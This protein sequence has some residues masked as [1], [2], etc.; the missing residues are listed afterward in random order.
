MQQIINSLSNAEPSAE[1][2]KLHMQALYISISTLSGIKK[3]GEGIF[4]LFSC[5]HSH[6][7]TLQ[8]S[9]EKY[10]KLKWTRP[11]SLSKL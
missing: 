3:I 7:V 10:T 9:L 11:L 5:K 1:L 2:E 8:V 6:C 4:Q